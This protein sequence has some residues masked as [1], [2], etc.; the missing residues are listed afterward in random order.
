[1]DM[2]KTWPDPPDSV[3]VSKAMPVRDAL[4]KDNR[5]LTDFLNEN[6]ANLSEEDRE[7]AAWE[8]RVSG[9]FMI[10]KHLKKYSVFLAKEGQAYGVLGLMS[11]FEEI[12]PFSPMSVTVTLLPFQDRI[13][14]DGIIVTRNVMFGGGIRGSLKE[15]L[16]DIEDSY[17]IFTSLPVTKADLRKGIVAGNTRLLKAF[18]NSLAGAGL[19]EKVILRDMATLTA[20]ASDLLAESKPLLE[21][22]LLTARAYLSQVPDSLTSLKRFARFLYDNARGEYERVDALQELRKRG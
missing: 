5:L 8:N 10:V 11:T 1:L 7:V 9:D 17:G 21:L 12:L 13:I 15:Q 4:W 18:R 2:D 19:S 20:V 22:D 16:K 6:P 14:F 3:S